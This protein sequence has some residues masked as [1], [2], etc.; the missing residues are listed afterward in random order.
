MPVSTC[1]H[2]NCGGNVITVEGNKGNI[3]Y[4]GDGGVEGGT[5]DFFLNDASYWGFSSTGDFMDDND[6]QNTRYYVSLAS[7]NISELYTTAHIS[8]PSITYF[9]YCLEN[10]DY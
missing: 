10:G 9:H 8:P 7:S 5:A 6:F 2:V 3:L 4:E 1:L